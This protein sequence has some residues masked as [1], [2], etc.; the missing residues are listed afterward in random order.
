MIEIKDKR[1][2]TGCGAC[3]NICPR[4]CISMQ[5]DGF[6]FIYPRIDVNTC[7][8]CGLCNKSCPMLSK[9]NALDDRGERAP[10]FY[11]GQLRDQEELFSVSSGGA[12]W[13]FAQAILKRGGIV[14]GAVHDDVDKISHF[15]A[16]TLDAARRLRRSKYLQSDTGL[17]Y[18]QV[19]KDL[20]AGTVVLFTGTGCQIA[21]LYAFLRKP[22]DELY[23]CDVVCHGVPSAL[24]WRQYREEKEAL[25]KKK[26]TGLI[27]RDKSLGWS[28]NQYCITYED[29]TQE[30][31]LSV[32][33]PF[34]AGYLSGLFSRPS[35]GTCRFACFPRGSDITL[36]DYWKYE[37]N[38]RSS[39]N[40]KGVSLIVVNTTHGEVLLD[41]GKEFLLIETTAREL[42]LASSRHLT[43]A[44]RENPNRAAFFRR[45]HR[46][47][48]NDAVNAFLHKRTFFQMIKQII[49]KL[50]HG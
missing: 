36:A 31:E 20:D 27:F 35:C 30:R 5:E 17:V 19:R 33:H 13:A 42:A 6:G 22:Y 26:I 29:G 11:A 7:I 43:H 40:D 25:E 46:A 49:G 41:Y 47:G 24:V 3:A 14:Y 2:C 45:F 8:R 32:R 21:A 1:L 48:Y 23:T 38:L 44:P 12:F 4:G 50:L 37:G 18:Q 9:D 34:H 10:L 15:R 28:Q 16:D 39:S